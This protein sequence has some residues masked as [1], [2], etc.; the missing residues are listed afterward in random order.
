MKQVE[1][2][3]DAAKM[4]QRM[5]RATAKRIRGKIR[6]YAEDPD[7]LANNVIIMKGGDGLRRMRVGDW[8]VIFTEDLVVIL[9][10]RVAPRGGAYD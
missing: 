3:R 4:L 5:D 7:S 6:Q 1:Y 9:V 8:R 2:A 10:I